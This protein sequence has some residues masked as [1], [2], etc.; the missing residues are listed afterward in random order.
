[1]DKNVYRDKFEEDVQVFR[2][3]HI[4]LRFQVLFLKDV[5]IA[6][7]VLAFLPIVGVGV[8]VGVAVSKSKSSSNKSTSSTSSG[9]TGAVKESDPNDPSTFQKDAKLKHS[10]YGLAYTP[11]GSQLPECGNSLG[12]LVEVLGSLVPL[13]LNSPPSR[14]GRHRGHSAH[15]TAHVGMC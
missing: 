11:E 7:D 10:F 15:F 9:S 6:G 8:G 12:M 4:D 5:E 2:V 13:N 1:M 3:L 14:R